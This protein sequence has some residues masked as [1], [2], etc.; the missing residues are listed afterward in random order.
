LVKRYDKAYFDRWYRSGA[1]V[2]TAES[3]RLR[4][5]LAVAAAEFVLGH[6]IRSVLDVGCGEAPWRA[7]LLRMRPGIHYE[8]V[9]SSEYVVQRF[10]VRRNIRLGSLGTLNRMKF[11]RKFDLVVCSDVVEYVPTAEVRRGFVAIRAL[12]RGVAYIEAYVDR[13]SFVGDTED[14][15]Y[16]SEVAYRR[17]FADARLYPCGL[18]CWVARAQLER[19]GPFEH[20]Q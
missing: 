13:E 3:R 18:N 5:R 4:V 14:W 7:D 19:L 2:V 17:A 20:C 1:A 12:L 15:H 6:P 16:R 11:R 10:G 8:G 9:D